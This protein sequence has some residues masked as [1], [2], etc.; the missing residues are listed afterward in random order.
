MSKLKLCLTIGAGLM[1]WVTPVATFSG[2]YLSRED[3]D[4][5]YLKSDLVLS[6]S[7]VLISGGRGRLIPEGDAAVCKIPYRHSVMPR[8]FSDKKVMIDGVGY[9][10]LQPDTG[11]GYQK[12]QNW[13]RD[14]KCSKTDFDYIEILLMGIPESEYLRYKEEWKRVRVPISTVKFGF[15]EIDGIVGGVK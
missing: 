15:Q 14:V 2:W 8:M 13:I 6:G 9:H 5:P 4:V 1:A 3:S 12:Y 11:P 10:L 7:P